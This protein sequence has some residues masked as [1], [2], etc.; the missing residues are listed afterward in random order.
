MRDVHLTGDAGS[1]G[2]T[3]YGLWSDSLSAPKVHHSIL[4]G[5]TNPLLGGAPKVAYTQLDGTLA[6]MPA[7]TCIGAYTFLFTPLGNT[8]T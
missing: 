1:T 3:G 4:R 2:T 6:S 8:C 5:S 7:N